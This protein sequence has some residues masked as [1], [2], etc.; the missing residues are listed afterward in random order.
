MCYLL[1]PF[2]A[3]IFLHFPPYGNIWSIRF[4]AFHSALMTAVWGLAWGLL[5]L[6]E[7]VCPLFLSMLARQL[8]FAMNVS[9]LLVWAALLITAYEGSRCAIIPYVHCL[10]V[11]LARRSERHARA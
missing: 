7:Q 3:G 2:S 6:L 5:R 9:F 8:R 11:R 1:G 10:A 4:H